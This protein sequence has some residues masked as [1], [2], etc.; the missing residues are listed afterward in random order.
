MGLTP[1]YVGFAESTTCDEVLN[2]FSVYGPLPTECALMYFSAL[3]T[4]SAFGASLPPFAM[5]TFELTMPSEVFATSTGIAGF[6]VFEVSTT[7]YGPLAA[8][9]MPA[10]RNDGLPFRFTSR[11]NE[12]TT[13]FDV[14]GVPSENLMFLRSVKVYVFASAEAL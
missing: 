5:T 11:L 13:S 3:S 10:S 7:V 1:Q 8:V 9:V 6:G 4:L 12:K 14:S 2:D